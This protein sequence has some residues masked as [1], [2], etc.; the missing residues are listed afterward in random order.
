MGRCQ[1]RNCASH[2]AATI[3]RITGR[4]IA[5][6]TPPTARPPLKPVPLGAIAEERYQA[7]AAVEVK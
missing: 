3:A 4:D 6:I 5:S 7:E 1:G 2:V